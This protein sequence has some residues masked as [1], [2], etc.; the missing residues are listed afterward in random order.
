MQGPV[1]N[2]VQARAWKGGG[3]KAKIPCAHRPSFF[4]LSIVIFSEHYQVAPGLPN[5]TDG[6]ID[7]III[8]YKYII[9]QI[10]FRCQFYYTIFNTIHHIS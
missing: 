2:H 5:V 6:C 10:I 4:L 9:I 8:I 7:I 3:P 1:Y